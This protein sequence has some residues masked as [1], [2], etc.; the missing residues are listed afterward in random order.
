M[1]NYR[2]SLTIKFGANVFPAQK[3]PS[4]EFF[5][6]FLQKSIVLIVKTEMMRTHQRELFLRLSHTERVDAALQ[7]TVETLY[8]K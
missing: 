5:F 7:A 2:N 4:I 6:F 3:C 1:D 8:E